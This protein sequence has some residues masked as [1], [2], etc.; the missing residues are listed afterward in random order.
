MIAAALIGALGLSG[1]LVAFA[2]WQA[3]RAAT[4][5]DRLLSL[6]EEK[7]ALERQLD[8]RGRAVE[9]RDQVI[10]KLEESV[11]NYRETLEKLVARAPLPTEEKD[12]IP[13]LR[14]ALDELKRLSPLPKT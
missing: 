3:R 6:T 13:A 11:A 14:A 10:N 2:F 7:G 8:A 5:M 9:E 12:A 4:A 1:A